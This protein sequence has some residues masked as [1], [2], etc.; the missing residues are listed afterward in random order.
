M[1]TTGCF[2]CNKEGHRIGE[3]PDI[4][5]LIAKNIVYQDENTKRIRMKDGSFIKRQAGESMAQ[6]ASR[7][8]TPRV[9][10]VT[11]E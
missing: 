11:V 3:C 10:F 2:G 6:A 5:E 1:D 7:L 8:S 9:M 4:Q